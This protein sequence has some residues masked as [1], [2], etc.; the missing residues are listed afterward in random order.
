MVL[1]QIINYVYVKVK[2]FITKSCYFFSSSA[3]DVC[4]VSS[5]RL[6]EISAVFGNIVLPRFLQSYYFLYITVIVSAI[7]L[8]DCWQ[9]LLMWFIMFETICIYF[10]AFY[11]SVWIWRIG[12]ALWYIVLFFAS[13][14]GFD[15]IH[16][17]DSRLDY[18]GANYIFK[19]GDTHVLLKSITFTAYFWAMYFAVFFAPFAAVGLLMAAPLLSF[20][21]AIFFGFLIGYIMIG[22]VAAS[23]IFI[24]F[25]AAVYLI[26]LFPMIR[27][28]Y[29][30]F[31]GTWEDEAVFAKNYFCTDPHPGLISNL[32]DSKSLNVHLDF[33]SFID[34]PFFSS[35]FEFAVDSVSA[36]MVLTITFISFLVHV[37]SISY[38]KNDPHTVRFFGLLG[39]FTFFMV[40]LVTSTDLIML[41][42]GW[43]GVG[44]SSY[45]LIAFWYTRVQAQKAATKAILVNKV[46]DVFLLFAI[47]LIGYYSRGSMSIFSAQEPSFGKIASA[48]SLFGLSGLDFICIALV[49]AAFVKSAQLFFHTWLPD[50]MEGPTPVSALL[51]AATMVTAGVYLVIRFSFLIEFSPTARL[52]MLIVSVWTVLT[53]SLIALFQYD[54]KK[55]IAYSTC[56]QLSI[57]FIGCSLSGYDFA[58]FHFF[59]HAFFK[60]L[61]FLIAGVIIHELRGEQDIR[62]MGAL[63]SVMPTTYFFFLVATLSLLGFPSFSGAVSKDLIIA[64]VDDQIIKAWQ[65][66]ITE[67]DLFYMFSVVYFIKVRA[68]IVFMTSAYM[69]RLI[70]YTF[71]CYPNFRKSCFGKGYV[72]V[73]YRN[74]AYCIIFSILAFI[75]IAGGK[76]FKNYFVT[77]DGYYVNIHNDMLIINADTGFIATY[78][79]YSFVTHASLILIAVVTYYVFYFLR[80]NGHALPLHTYLQCDFNIFRYLFPQWFKK[81]GLAFRWIVNE[82]FDEHFIKVYDVFC[83]FNKRCYFD[84]VYNI[85]LGRGF[86]KLSWIF[87]KSFER[88]LLAAVSDLVPF[89]NNYVKTDPTFSYR[90]SIYINITISLLMLVF[91]I[92]AFI[93]LLMR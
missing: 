86:L 20:I 64:L 87:R 58:L 77:T 34:V 5:M 29:L 26:F 93:A 15:I 17:F 12:F 67:A 49:L 82:F 55:I 76:N 23:L 11:S 30:S 66:V 31:A 9:S 33:G 69:I 35:N 70:Y 19:V 85:H 73:S 4:T 6:P 28:K 91:I 46:G 57:M 39:L 41:Y 48:D 10:S 56:G 79:S 59:N 88:G 72:D 27:E 21:Y 18:I 63:Y 62:G 92:V 14:S 2:S 40:M 13:S 36:I 1:Y 47:T 16:T 74:K 42:I 60:C 61:L 83:F 7:A 54:I 3:A 8:V 84:D 80:T 89:V 50:A 71:F 43:E 51:H 78:N 38:M 24:A 45:L 53:T 52:L 37:Y 25:L 68:A 22:Y 32:R 44:L 65:R 81:R 90:Q 75:S